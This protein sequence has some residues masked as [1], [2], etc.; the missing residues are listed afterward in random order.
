MKLVMKRATQVES[1][2]DIVRKETILTADE[3]YAAYLYN[4]ADVVVMA[5]PETTTTTTKKA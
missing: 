5:E 3:H 1:D 4:E 2:R